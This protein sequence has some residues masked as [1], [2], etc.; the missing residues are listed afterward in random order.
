[1][2]HVWPTYVPVPALPLLP[3]DRTASQAG[4]PEASSVL[5]TVGRKEVDSVTLLH[6]TA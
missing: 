5:L 2:W 3:D 6:G 4:L 1:M